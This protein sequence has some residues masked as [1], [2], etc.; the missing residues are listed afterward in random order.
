MEHP[1]LHAGQWVLV[2][3]GR[4]AI[5]LENV[6]DA[7]RVDLRSKEVHEHEDAPTRE[8]G[9]D[10]PGRS[11]ATTGTGRSSMEQTDWHD[12][13]EKA[14]LL[15]LAK[16]LNSAAQAG[17]TKAITIIA[18]PRA[19]GMLRPALSDTTRAIVK[20]EIAKDYVKKSIADIAKELAG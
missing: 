16:R 9:S 14:F 1:K 8:L 5:I 2:C 15:G 12:E 3:D 17:E 4:K 6:G 20:S 13:A 11:F 10:A 18:A 7:M 19:L